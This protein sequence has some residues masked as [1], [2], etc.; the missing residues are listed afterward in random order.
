MS[1]SRKL[2]EQLVSNEINSS[3]LYENYNSE[4]LERLAHQTFL[5]QITQESQVEQKKSI[6]DKI[7]H[8]YSIMEDG[9]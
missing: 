1:L 2:I 9:E 4:I 6:Q 5:I 8:F 3:A 7:E